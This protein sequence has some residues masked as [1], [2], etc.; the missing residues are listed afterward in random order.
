MLFNRF[1]ISL[2]VTWGEGNIHT[3]LDDS[4]FNSSNWDGTNSRDLVNILKW[5]SKWL[6]VWSN[7]GWKTIN[8][9]SKTKT[10][11]PRHAF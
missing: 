10:L 2:M 9:V 4:S 8:G 1:N 5:K 3:W 7:R 6:V 11:I